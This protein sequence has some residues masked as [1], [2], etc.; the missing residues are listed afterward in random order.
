MALRLVFIICFVCMSI[1]D[2]YS[3]ISFKTEYFGTSNYWVSR[4]DN[5]RE[6]VEDSKGSGI[7]YQGSIN[8]PLSVKTS[9]NGKPVIWG[10]GLGGSYASLNNKNFTDDL[11][12]SDILNLD[13]GFYHMRP[14]SRRWSVL[15]SI[16]AGIY[17]PSTSFSQI[18]AKHILGSVSTIFICQIHPNLELGGGIAI[19]STFGYP[20]A[21]PALY[22]NWQ[23]HGKFDFILSLTNGLKISSGFDVNK[24]LKLSLIAEMNGQTA[25]LEKDGKDVIFTHQYIV[26][27]LQSAIKVS[28]KI[29]FPITVGVNAERPAY[30]SDRTL[31]AM[32]KSK[33][34]YYFQVS[35]YL[36]AGL[37][38]NY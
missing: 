13:L 8:L 27:G 35:P 11:V 15:A 33:D 28:N 32:F 29:S 10:L 30:F 36:S 9:E 25:L 26:G 22:L 12:I 1:N 5:P 31:K 38:I 2:G 34:N 4:G 17:S 3:Q 7:V 21:F 14:I 23:L 24:Y 16:G 19:N 37:T 6:R 18:R 20:M